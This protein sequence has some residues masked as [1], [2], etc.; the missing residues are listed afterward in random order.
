MTF[1]GKAAHAA[2]APHLGINAGA[3]ATL[4]LTAIALLRQQLPGGTNLNAFVS[5]GGEVTNII[6][7]KTVLQVEVRAAELD[8]WRQMK[9]QVL[10]CFEGA[11]IATGTQ[12]DY[13]STEYAYAPLR[14]DPDLARLWDQNVPAVGRTINHTPGAL[15]GGSTDMG[16]VSQVVPAIHPVIA[17]LGETAA[18]HSPAFTA[19]AATTAADQA[20]L[21]GATLLAWTVVDAAT[22]AELRADLL[23][24]HRERP[25]GATQEILQA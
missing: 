16:N 22:D 17:F 15:G 6:P 23:R 21:D 8:V 2:A 1:T 25:A 13:R 3:A 10:A 24:R 9:K 4:A 18:P 20:A 12:W 19:A 14:H 5:H 7:D 11:A